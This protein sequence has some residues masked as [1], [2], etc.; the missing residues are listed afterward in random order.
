M[1]RNELLTNGEEGEFQLWALFFRLGFSLLNIYVL[2]PESRL[3][4]FGGDI[5]PFQERYLAAHVVC[6][7]AAAGWRYRC[8]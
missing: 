2:L 6:V 1:P 3:L 5:Q 7:T 4:E 8:S